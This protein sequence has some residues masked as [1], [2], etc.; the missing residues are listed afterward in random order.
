[1]S[2]KWERKNREQGKGARERGKKKLWKKY[3]AQYMD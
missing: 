1:M 2:M 3:Q